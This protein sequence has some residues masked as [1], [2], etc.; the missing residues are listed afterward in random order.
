M[1]RGGSA[2]FLSQK[3]GHT[4]VSHVQNSAGRLALLAASAKPGP[5]T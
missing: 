2:G 3:G 1:E 5:G 4:R